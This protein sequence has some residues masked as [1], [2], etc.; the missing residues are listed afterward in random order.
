MSTLFNQIIVLKSF[1]MPPL[2]PELNGLVLLGT[3]GAA[4]VV[5]ISSDGATFEPATF[6]SAPLMPGTVIRMTRNASEVPS[7]LNFLQPLP[8]LPARASAHLVNDGV[9]IYAPPN[10]APVLE[11][12]TD[13]V[14]YTLP[15]TLQHPAALTVNQGTD[16]GG[17]YKTHTVPGGFD[18]AQGDTLTD[19]GG[20]GVLTLN[21]S[22]GQDSDLAVGEYRLVGQVAHYHPALP[23]S[24]DA[25]SFTTGP[26][27]P[28]LDQNAF[29]LDPAPANII[30][31]QTSLRLR[32]GDN[33]TQELTDQDAVGGANPFCWQIYN[34]A[35]FVIIPDDG[36]NRGGLNP[37]WQTVEI[38]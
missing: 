8:S 4:M 22:A 5:A 11:V 29:F 12:R 24:W 1:T 14:T 13:G 20:T 28:T 16:P 7:A 9:Q 6:P 23:T 32:D 35:L 19:A 30:S 27:N 3:T 15:L 36:T 18:P 26:S 21:A 38:F 31:G 10:T 17:L 37:P 2:P 25:L 33:N 34:G